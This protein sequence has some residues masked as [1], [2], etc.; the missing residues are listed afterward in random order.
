MEE[1]LLLR[2]GYN[3][4]I[5]NTLAD[6]CR[7]TYLPDFLAIH[8]RVLIDKTVEDFLLYRVVSNLLN[9]V[10]TYIHVSIFLSFVL[11]VLLLLLILF[12]SVSLYFSFYTLSLYRLLPCLCPP[13]SGPTLHYLSIVIHLPLS[14]LMGGCL[15]TPHRPPREEIII[16]N[17]SKCSGILTGIKGAVSRVLTT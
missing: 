7:L 10:Q 12:L 9:V 16:N 5:C 3:R 8:T 4:L 6:S 15:L 11:S 2:R 14:G 17:M 13:I 1:D